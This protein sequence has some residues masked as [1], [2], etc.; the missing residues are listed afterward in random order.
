MVLVKERR[1]TYPHIRLPTHCLGRRTAPLQDNHEP[2]KCSDQQK[3]KQ[4]GDNKLQSQEEEQQQQQI[5][6]KN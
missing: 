5:N 2:I 1:A 6:T 3:Q 4:D